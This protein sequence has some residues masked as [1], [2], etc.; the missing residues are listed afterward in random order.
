MVLMM[1]ILPCFTSYRSKAIRRC[2]RC[3]DR[4]EKRAPELPSRGS[5]EIQAR[6][7]FSKRSPNQN[8]TRGEGEGSETKEG[9]MGGGANKT[10]TADEQAAYTQQLLTN[11]AHIE[12]QLSLNPKINKIDK[13]DVALRPSNI[14]AFESSRSRSPNS[15]EKRRYQYR[16]PSKTPPFSKII[17]PYALSNDV[18]KRGRGTG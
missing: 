9:T 11:L 14:K 8:E 7:S 18:S 17:R 5:L 13:V 4:G 12:H 3:I 15:Q 10:V 16:S 6:P 1:I 2:V